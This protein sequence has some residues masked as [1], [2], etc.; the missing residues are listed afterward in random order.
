MVAIFFEDGRKITGLGVI[1]AVPAFG[2]LCADPHSMHVESETRRPSIP[3]ERMEAQDILSCVEPFTAARPAE[4]EVLG[5]TAVR[6]RKPP[7]SVL[8]HDGQVA[9]G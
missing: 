8:A 5:R 1:R 9:D 7:A 3:L 2:P 4:L 6:V